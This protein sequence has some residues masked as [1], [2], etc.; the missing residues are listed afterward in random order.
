[1]HSWR[2][3]VRHALTGSIS[4][5]LATAALPEPA[6][7]R[8]TPSLRQRRAVRAEASTPKAEDVTQD[9]KAGSI[10]ASP[11]ARP[12]AWIWHFGG[13]LGHLSADGEASLGTESAS[14]KVSGTSLALHTD[15]EWRIAPALYLG[16]S[17]LF[18]SARNPTLSADGAETELDEFTM[19]S[20][21][22]GP[23]ISYYFGGDKGLRLQGFLGLWTLRAT[24]ENGTSAVDSETCV[25][26]AL[27][28]ALGYDIAVGAKHTLGLEFR[29]LLAHVSNEEQDVRE[30][31][32]VLAPMLSVTASF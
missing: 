32:T 16:G 17:L 3:A 23:S 7:A 26:P 30:S 13:G 29:T 10:G 15:L 24:L 14:L 5:L 11:G 21:G 22:L 18:A 6:E 9:S 4:A 20:V 12:R 31:Y 27:G 25:G 8:E 19:R 1:M 28:G 2:V